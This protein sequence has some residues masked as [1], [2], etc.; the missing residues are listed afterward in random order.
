VN[1]SEN[2][3]GDGFITAVAVGGFLIVVGLVFA[4]NPDLWQ[5]IV[6]FFN[7]ITTARFPFGGATS[8]IAL[9]APENPFAHIALYNA[10]FQFDMGFGVVQLLVLALRVWT[11]S[12]INRVA[13]SLGD[14]IFWLGAALLVNIFLL[15]GTQDGWF[16]YW[17]ALIIVV[18][19]SFIG[20]GLVYFVKRK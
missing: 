8:S 2:R 9:P 19:I 6:N 4:L 14:V 1:K 7:D 5:R 16:E 20:R 18:G 11:R 10:V 15:K 17:A 12:R 13:E 3:R